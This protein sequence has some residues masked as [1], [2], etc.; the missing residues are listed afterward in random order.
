MASLT[1][2]QAGECFGSRFIEFGLE[3]EQRAYNLPAGCLK[4]F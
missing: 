1:V 2:Q 4:K 3:V